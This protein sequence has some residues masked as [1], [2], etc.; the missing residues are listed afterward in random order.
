MTMG[1]MNLVDTSPMD[2]LYSGRVLCAIVLAL[3]IEDDVLDSR[4]ARR[5]FAGE[6]VNEHN[7]NQIFD[8][9]GQALITR[10]LAPETLDDLPED[11]PMAAA[12]G[13]SVMMACGKW[14][15]LMAHLQGRSGKITDVGEAGTEFLRL[16]IV[17]LALRL[18]ALARLNLVAL[19]KLEPPIWVL[20]NGIGNIL[21]QHLRQAGLTRD[22]LAARLEVSPT[23]VDNWLDGR[24]R[25]SAGNVTPLAEELASTGGGR[26]AG[27]LQR[28]LNRQ[29]SLASIAELLATSIGRDR[30]IELTAR[31]AHFTRVLSE[32]PDLPNLLG[33]NSSGVVRN[34]LILGCAGGSAPGL[35]AWLADREPDPGWRRDVLAAAGPWEPSFERVS[36]MH[37]GPRSAAGLAQDIS[38]VPGGTTQADHYV[39]EALRREASARM[40]LAAVSPANEIGLELYLARLKGGIDLRRSLAGRFPQSPLAHYQL[41]SYLGMLGKNFGDRNLIDEGIL[42]CK[43]ATGLLPTWD[44]PAVEPGIILANIGDGHAAL[45]ELDQAES[46]LPRMTPHLRFVK[47]YVLTTLERYSEAL[48]YLKAVIE[49]RPDHAPAYDSAAHCAF[50]S[51]DKTNGLRYAKVARLLGMPAEYNAWGDSL[52]SSLPR[53]E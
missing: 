7:R 50:M 24:N 32:S 27:E 5:F 41:G 53:S 52:Y 13:I 39:N 28:E 29:F 8:A 15:R 44:S 9:F 16:V 1:D 48:E 51:G 30:V 36:M 31:L 4:T 35:L 34:L 40:D 47:G 43:I 11:L 10:G 38:D 49:E 42:E 21:R 46:I 26:G 23:S 33:D 14:D 37:I 12:V 20:E 2:G 18:F 3:D 25:P 17:D 19:P 22:Q 6:S 45:R